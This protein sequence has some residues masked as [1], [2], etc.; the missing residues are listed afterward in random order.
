MSGVTCVF[1]HPWALAVLS[2]MSYPV[3]R[4]KVGDTLSDARNPKQSVSW[5]WVCATTPARSGPTVP[6]PH[7]LRPRCAWL[8][9]IARAL[10]HT[11]QPR[12]PICDTRVS[13]KW[14]VWR[15]SVIEWLSVWP[16][17]YR[18]I[19]PMALLRGLSPRL[20]PQDPDQDGTSAERQRMAPLVKHLACVKHMWRGNVAVHE[21]CDAERPW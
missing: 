21:T 13:G 1:V 11:F 9:A 8:H 10:A 20:A 7:H 19:Y 5:L 4:R 3:A 2:R 14:G 16:I 12:P 18:G 15:W 6:I 17:L